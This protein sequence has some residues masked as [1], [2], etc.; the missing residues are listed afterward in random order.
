MTVTLIRH[1][2]TIWHAAGRYQG[3]SDVPL[4]PEGTAKLRPAPESPAAV[5][6]T[7]LR[8]TAQTAQRLFPGA[9]L[10]EVPGLEEM[11]F[12][13]FEGKSYQELKGRAD[14]R[15]WLDGGCLA[16]CPEGESK[17]TFCRRVCAAF[18]RL[19]D[20]ADAPELTLV[21]HDG[22]IMAILERFGSPARDYFAWHCAPGCGY[23]LDAADWPSA[24]TLRLVETLH[25]TED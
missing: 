3:A 6:V 5:Y 22:T 23:R 8:R 10:H 24:R 12:G 18:A 16:P 9:V 4:S 13:V 20:S 17:E 15:A 2:E 19:M 1:G 21:A 11:D 7:K 14:Y 25:F